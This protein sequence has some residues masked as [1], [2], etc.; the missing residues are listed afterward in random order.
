MLDCRSPPQPRAPTSSVMRALWPTR[1]NHRSHLGRLSRIKATWWWALRAIRLQDC[2]PINEASFHTWLCSA[3][4]KVHKPHRRGFDTIATLIAW[5]I[6][7]EWNNRVFNNESRTWVDIAKGMAEE[8]ALWRAANSVIP[9]LTS[10]LPGGRG[11]T[12]VLRD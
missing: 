9:S 12:I 11:S 5:T 6:W 1:R 7:K 8:A 2:L 10:Q 3:R 4:E